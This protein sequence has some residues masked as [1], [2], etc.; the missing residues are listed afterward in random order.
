MTS[1]NK[2]SGW[3]F[4]KAFWVANLVELLERAA[5]YGFFIAVTLYLTDVVGYTDIQSGWIAGVFAA[6]LYFLPTFSGALADKIGFRAAIILAFTLLTIGYFSLGILPYKSTVIPA[7][8]I[9]MIGGSFIKSVIS[10]TVAKESNAHNRAR[11]YSIFYWMVNIGAFSGK[12]FAYPIRMDLG[13]VYIQYYSAALSF[14]ALIAVFLF[15]KSSNTAGQG[16][17]LKETW[18]AFIKVCKNARL[19]WLI[20]IVTGFWM[21]QHQLYA[22]MPKFVIRMVGPEASPEWIANVNPFVVVL[23]VLFVTELG[24]RISALTSISI[25]MFLIPISAFIM[26]LGP[27]LLG[28]TGNDVNVLGLIMSPITIMMI[29]GIVFQALGET[30]ISPRF[31]GVFFTSIPQRRRGFVSWFQ[32]SALLPCQSAGIHLIGLSI[33]EILSQVTRNHFTSRKTAA[34]ANAHYIW[35]YYAVVGVIA[36]FALV[37]YARVTKK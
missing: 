15:Y 8:L 32:P 6:G 28:I 20:I 21:I 11:A 24:K 5:Y 14:L 36:A 16:K 17:S 10:G 34:Y 31:F 27:W 1:T 22:S 7:L 13:V 18:N 12:M 2:L 3:R 29:I 33:G 19:V 25:G 35:Y 30:F 9:I 37:V 4:P 23:T 26:S